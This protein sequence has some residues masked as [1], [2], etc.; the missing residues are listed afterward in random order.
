MLA[1]WLNF[2]I[3]TKRISDWAPF[4]QVKVS[5]YII[6]HSVGGSFCWNA[7]SDT[8]YTQVTT[9]VAIRQVF[10]SAATMQ[11]VLSVTVK[12]VD[13]SVAIMHVM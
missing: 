1:H 12:L 3:V 11:V 6:V 10:F 7:V 9:S 4:V 13:L 5:V 2:F 8:L